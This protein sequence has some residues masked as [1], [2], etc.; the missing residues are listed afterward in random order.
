MHINLTPGIIVV[1]TACGPG[2]QS[3]EGPRPVSDPTPVVQPASPEPS[4]APKCA[5]EPGMV[6]IAGGEHL[7]THDNKRYSVSPFWIDRTEVT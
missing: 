6:Y 4:A 1:L 5:D 3:Q 2:Q 7:A